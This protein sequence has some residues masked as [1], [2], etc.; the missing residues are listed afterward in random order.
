MSRIEELIHELCP[1]GVE[2]ETLDKV[3]NINKGKQLNKDS[4]LDDG[5]YPVI[6]GGINPSG[7]WNDYNYREE[8]ITISQGGASA[9]YISYRLTKFWAGAHCYVVERCREKVIYKY[10]YHF[11]K[12]RE[13]DLQ[14]SQVGAGIPSISLSEIYSLKIPVPPLEVQ[15]EI[16][17]I[18]DKFGELEEELEEELEARKS[19]YEFWRDKLLNSENYKSKKL[20]E[21]ATFSQG[22]QVDPKE[23]R[24]N[25]EEGMVPFLRI[26][27]FVKED[28]PPRYIVKPAEKY[29]KKEN[30]EMVMIRYGANAAGKVFINKFGAIANNM[31]KIN[32][33]TNEVSVKFVWYYLSQKKIYNNLNNSGSGSTM[34]AINFKVVSNLEIKIPSL[35]EQERIVDILDKFDKLVNDISEGL[36]AET[37]ARRKQYEYYRNKL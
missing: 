26:V 30:E 19:Q 3:C 37:E 6:N 23:Q 31:F 5:L 28:E 12:S 7:Y 18:L 29:L 8:L 27:D 4:L 21:L 1:N 24:L 15:E 10:L 16:V 9:G 34:P 13:K 33:L 20:G 36:P 32:L 25:F 14:N 2:Y 11:L 35:D 22:I 17:R